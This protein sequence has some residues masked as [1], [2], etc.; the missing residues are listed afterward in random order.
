MVLG[1]SLS[2][3]YNISWESGWVNLLRQHFQQTTNPITVINASVGGATTQNGLQRL[4][5]LL[6]EHKP[7]IV[8]VELG[9]NDGLQGKPISY[10]T[11]NLRQLITLCKESKASV[12]LVGN[13]LPP[14]LGK[15]YTEPFFNQ[16]TQLA[17][18]EETL[19]LPFM[20][21]DIAGNPELMQADGLH[22]KAEGQP[23]ILQHM[24]PLIEQALRK[25]E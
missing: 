16:Y 23:I 20:L 17:N 18:S 12:I 8:I 24:L 3:A 4:P 9:A 25:P 10:I 15:R 11:Q 19:L 2:A 5:K 6:A 22:P 14:N 21:K 13:R 7:N 1:D